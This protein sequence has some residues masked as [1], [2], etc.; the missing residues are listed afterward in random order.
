M[1]PQ[2]VF[3][4][5]EDTGETAADLFEGL[6]D[7]LALTEVTEEELQ[8]ARDKCWVVVHHQIEQDPKKHASSLTVQIQL[9]SLRTGKTCIVK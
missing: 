5:T 8:S 3:H 2:F 7:F 1:V 9:S 4:L 6:K